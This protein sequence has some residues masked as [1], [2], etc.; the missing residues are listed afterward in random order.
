MWRRTPTQGCHCCDCGFFPSLMKESPVENGDCSVGCVG[1]L[2][3][4]VDCECHC[5]LLWECQEGSLACYGLVHGNAGL[6]QEPLA[7][8]CLCY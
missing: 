7:H 3:F 1:M 6:C 5:Q 4:H 2:C 8:N